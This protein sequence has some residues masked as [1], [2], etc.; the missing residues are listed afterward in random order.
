LGDHQRRREALHLRIVLL[1]PDDQS[2]QIP[3]HTDDAQVL[4]SCFTRIFLILSAKS[5]TKSYSFSAPYFIV[6]VIVVTH[7]FI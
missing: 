4:Q 3:A 5:Y 2:R 6:C 1:L 7:C